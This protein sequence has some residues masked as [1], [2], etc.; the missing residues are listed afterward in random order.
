MKFVK[1]A[2]AGALIAGLSVTS[3]MADYNKG[4]KYY[5]KMVKK[6]SK[7]KSSQLIKLLNIKTPAQLEK[8]LANDAKGLIAA[9]KKAGQEKAA[10]G[11]EKIVKKGKL[12]DLKDFLIGIM[13]GK[14]PAGCS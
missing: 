4:F 10:K 6:K 1:L 8:L 12:K 2:L 11:I 7:L 3:A 5:N 14:I 9:L 13:N